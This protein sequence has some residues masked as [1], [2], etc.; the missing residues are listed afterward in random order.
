MLSADMLARTVS[1][2]S[3]LGWRLQRCHGSDGRPVLS[4]AES[5][6]YLQ[7]YSTMI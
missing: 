7:F 6:N 3:L 5:I 2:W 4:E 1:Q